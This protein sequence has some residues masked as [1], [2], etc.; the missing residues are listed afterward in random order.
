MKRGHITEVDE[1]YNIIPDE[2]RS[3]N[4]VKLDLGCGQNKKTGYLGVD[5]KKIQG[6]DIVHDLNKYPYPFENNSIFEIYCSHFIEHVKNIKSFMEECYRILKP[7]SIIQIIAP[8]YTSIRAFQDYTH[9]RPISEN[10]FLYFNKKWIN[11]NKLNHYN[12]AC[13]FNIIGIKYRYSAEWQYKS[14]ETL[15]WARKHY[16]NVVLD[17]EVY[18][19]KN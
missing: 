12:I 16:W 6:I 18:L 4:I 15:E 13:D 3:I 8:Y 14:K 17:I 2:E 19:R 11:D 10:T 1:E 9:I 7:E 5:I